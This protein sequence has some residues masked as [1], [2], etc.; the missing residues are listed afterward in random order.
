MT[1]TASKRAHFRALHQSGCFVLPNPWDV[2]SAR[3][4]QHLGFKALAS[5]SSGHAWT[6]G[7]ADYAVTRDDVLAH[8][9]ALSAAVDLPVNADFEFGF[10][11]EPA[12]VAAAVAFLVSPAARYITGVM[13]PV[14]GGY[15]IA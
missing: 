4:L 3:L 14:D 2:G 15:S 11:V 9:A 10:A 12:D 1:D 5:T 8:L 7:R 13:L 6:R